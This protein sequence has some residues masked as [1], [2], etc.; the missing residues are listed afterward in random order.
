MIS[1]ATVM[2]KP[3]SRVK[4][5]SSGPSP[6]VIPRKKRSEVST[7][8]RHVMVSGLMSSLQSLRRCS[9]VSSSGS[10]TCMPSF[11][12]LT[13]MLLVKRRLPFLFSGSKRLNI[14]SS[15]ASFSWNM[16][17]SMAAASR[18]LAAVIACKSPVRC[19]LNSSIGTTCE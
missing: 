2:S 5:F 1:E 13:S 14:C 6:M 12:S 7:T 16:R 11:S 4:P 8:R 19:K 10:E 15:V 3:V 18:L 9:G 17:A